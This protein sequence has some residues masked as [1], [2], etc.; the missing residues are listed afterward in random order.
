MKGEIGLPLEK[1]GKLDRDKKV[2]FPTGHLR[3]DEAKCS[4]M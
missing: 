4:F 3:T 1:D 2:V